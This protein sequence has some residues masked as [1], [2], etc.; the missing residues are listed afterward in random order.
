MN[1][2]EEF[3]GVIGRTFRESEPWWP[4][5]PTAP[6]DRPNVVVILFD[7]T[8]FS[9]LG[10]YGSTIA[11]PNIDRLA[12]NGLRFTN[13]H[14]T[15]L[16]S[17]TRASLLT[18]RNHHAV[19]MRSISSY[20]PGY[21]NMRGAVSRNAATMAEMLRDENY[22]TFAVGKWHLNPSETCS[23]AGP[24][25][26]W[27]LQRGFDRYYGFLSGETDQF[28]PDLCY[29]NHLIDPPRTPEEGYH[30]T[31]DI[32]D[33]ATGFLR[34]HQ[35]VYPGQPFFLY[36]ALGATHSPHQAPAEY[37]ER[38]RGEFDQGWDEVRKEWF[39]RQLELGV[40][41]EGTELAP[42]NPG[43]KPWN[44]FSP[45]M[46]RFLAA[47]QEAFAGFLTHTDEQIGR[48]ISYLDDSG[49]LDNT[50]LMLMADNG[51]SQE[52]GPQGVSDT[53]RYGQPL[54][55]D[56][57]EAQSRLHEIGGPRSSP[58]YPWGWSQAGNTPL[59]WYKQNTHGG[60]VRVPLIVH[61]P[62]RITDTG[63]FRRQFHHVSDV[64]PT[65]L[66]SVQATAPEEYAGHRQMPVSG[67][68]F[69]YAFDDASADTAKEAQ[70]FEMLGHRGIWVNG[71]KAVTRHQK[72]DPW[73]DDEWE[74]YHVAEDF[75]E[76]NNLA[77]ENPEKLRELV[78]RWWVE[79]GRYGVLPLDDRSFQ[80]GGPTQRPGGPHNGLKYRYT[81]PV[82]HLP[83]EIAPAVGLGSWVLEADIERDS[84]GDGVIFSRGSVMGGI[85]FYIKDN[86]L[87]VD[88]N[89]FT[90][91][92]EIVSD[93]EV[94]EGRCTIGMSMDGEAPSA[95]GHVTIRL[96]GEAVGEGDVPFLVRG[97][98]GGR[99]GADIGSDRKS[100]VT[101]SYE[102]PFEFDGTIHELTLEVTPYPKSGAAYE[103]AR[104]AFKL[105]MAQQ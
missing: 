18:G 93:V 87:R 74:L 66:E 98:F 31:E 82:S 23:Q 63:S 88:Y 103:A 61:W 91:V 57:D 56:V 99:G 19:G 13:F 1:Q 8:G 62:D 50:I 90:E 67:T 52:G 41:P 96:N 83:G 6:Q 85:S 73:G 64:L 81:P 104:N 3:G 22:A 80:L 33:Q 97:G 9:H 20:D 43:V 26:D 84:G 105:L 72:N 101:S 92:T 39:A 47:F 2:Q 100:P 11:T 14:V 78:D 102:A 51:A 77:A 40:I 70:Y 29:D 10:C 5:L 35:S 27:P 75:S 28:Y 17:P 42:R 79:A 4:E 32:V 49:Q 53:A 95:P 36:F 76:S 55:D 86:R 46:K 54:L 25:H 71:W 60:G 7:D 48:L 34:D 58:N 21:P 15:A 65:V 69:A 44:D 59:K 12:A 38:Y 37:I 94:P 45:N 24:F 16:C 30:F 68:S 89:A